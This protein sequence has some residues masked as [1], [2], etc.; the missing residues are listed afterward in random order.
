MAK[1]DVSL[2]IITDK[3]REIA[4][5]HEMINGFEVGEEAVKGYSDDDEANEG[6]GNKELS[7]PY[8]WVDYDSTSYDIGEARSISSKTYS[9]RL[10]VA[11]KQSDNI[12][13]D[14]DIMSD[15]E[16]ILS[17]IVQWLLSKEE[18]RKIIVPNGRINATP[19]IDGT[20]DGAHGWSC[21]IPL[22]IPYVF[23]IENLPITPK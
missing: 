23:C 14:K 2:R 15:T 6:K 11:D 8:L 5:C 20:K 1:K 16:G 17:D 3:L 13:S 9:M 12:K 7:Y 22:K 19:T 4:N 21:T 10:F 18:L